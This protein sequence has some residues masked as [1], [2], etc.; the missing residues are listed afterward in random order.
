MY[1]TERSGV[2]SIKDVLILLP[3]LKKPVHPNW[4]GLLCSFRKKNLEVKS[5]SSIV[6]YDVKMVRKNYSRIDQANIVEDSP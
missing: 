2:V 4:K 6:F 5:G 1:C 3:G